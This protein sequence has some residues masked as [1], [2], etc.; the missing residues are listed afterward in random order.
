MDRK[1]LVRHSLRPNEPE[2][3]TSLRIPA[4]TSP[5][6]RFASAGTTVL[7]RKCSCGGTPGPSGECEECRRKRL[8]RKSG[9]A[10]AESGNS[11]FA[12]PIVH[13]VL[14]S[15]GEPLDFATRAFFEPRFGHDL[16][17]I[18]IHTGE[19]PTQSAKA[20]GALA[21]TVGPEVVFA[22]EHY[23]PHTTEGRVLLGHE[24]AH[25]M[26]QGRAT[27]DAPITVGTHEY[28]EREA[29]EA[30]RMIAENRGLKVGMRSSPAVARQEAPD[31]GAPVDAGAPNRS[32]RAF[33]IN[34]PTRGAPLMESFAQS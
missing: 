6:L 23:A 16:S 11:T 2:M 34:N 31:A 22:R 20:V 30:S 15:P 19:R 8:Q 7:Q 17:H 25:T 29:N 32:L 3:I 27:P 28:A 10:K 33:G 26:Q 24:L 13:E 1:V 5:S 12:P 4:K 18:R 14:R 9:S 21:Y